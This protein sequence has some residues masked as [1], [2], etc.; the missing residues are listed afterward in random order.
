MTPYYSDSLVTLFH[1]DCR[2]VLPT[3]ANESIDLCLTDPPYG[4]NLENHGRNDG[5]RRDRSWTIIGDESKNVGQWVIDYCVAA[6][7]PLICFASP[8]HPWKGSWRSL[9][10][11][12][13]Y[14]LG[15]GGDPATCWRRDW[16]LIQVSNNGK[17]TGGRDSAVLMGYDIRPSDFLLHPCQKPT[18]LL[19]Y[20]IGKT[21]P[22]LILDP[23][24]GSGST[25]V[26][27]KLHGR[28]AIG[29]EI[30]ERYCEVAARRLSQG[31]LDFE[32]AAMEA[33]TPAG[34]VRAELAGTGTEPWL[35][36]WSAGLID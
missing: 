10:V 22:R 27:A 13:K 34:S 18:T 36:R 30:E 32:P 2:E 5:H 15:M 35:W 19:C 11:W 33:K 28:K 4:I 8:E 16:E 1:G 12:H 14:G 29:I 20:L 6:G 26:A 17:L 23:F 25:L 24:V 21:N 31:V 9:L 3:L 7:W